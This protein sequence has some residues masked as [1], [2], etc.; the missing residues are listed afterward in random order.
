MRL[1]WVIV[2]SALALLPCCGFFQQPCGCGE[3]F[4]TDPFTGE[5]DVVGPSHEVG[6]HC[7]C[8]CGDDPEVLEP[9]S[10]QCE[11][12]EGDCRTASGV[13]SQYRCE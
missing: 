1:H 9:P 8:Q 13:A 12:Y 10:A 3:S 5:I 2:A 11:Q 7:V 4:E 6:V